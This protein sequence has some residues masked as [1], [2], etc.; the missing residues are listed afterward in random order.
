VSSGSTY[1]FSRT[2]SGGFN[3][4]YRQTNDKKAGLK[5]RGISVEFN[6]QFAF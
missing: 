5:Q 2:I 1:N 6:A 4:A 3:F